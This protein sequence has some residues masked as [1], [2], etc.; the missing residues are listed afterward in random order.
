MISNVSVVASQVHAVRTY[1]NGGFE[2]VRNPV[3]LTELI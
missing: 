2:S 1:S 3:Y